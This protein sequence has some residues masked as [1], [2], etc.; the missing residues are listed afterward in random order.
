VGLGSAERVLQV[1]QAYEELL[2]RALVVVVL[3]RTA[4]SREKET[5]ITGAVDLLAH[6][7][8]GS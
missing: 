1:I 6:S 5:F 7:R 4:L 8:P 2:A 3:A